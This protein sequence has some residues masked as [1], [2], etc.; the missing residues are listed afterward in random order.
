MKCFD[1]IPFFADYRTVI[2][3]IV[4]DEIHAGTSYCDLDFEMHDMT[5]DETDLF[6]DISR[7]I[8][9]LGRGERS[10]MVHALFLSNQTT[11]NIVVISND[12]EAYQV[13]HRL[14]LKDPDLK[15]RFPNMCLIKWVRT[16]DAIRR[17]WEKGLLRNGLAEEIYSEMSRLLG[18]KNLRFLL[19]EPEI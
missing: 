10:A 13:F 1:C 3:N 12:K 17:M 15:K 7:Y 16:Y 9:Q 6:E 11:D 8:Y 19:E 5:P 14:V 4:H 2:T 18:E